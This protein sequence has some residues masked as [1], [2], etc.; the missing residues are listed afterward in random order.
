MD[1]VITFSFNFLYINEIIYLVGLIQTQN[2]APNHSTYLKWIFISACLTPLY[3]TMHILE[4]NILKYFPNIYVL[5][6]T[7]I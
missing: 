5:Y 7:V 1:W 2:Y 6:T 4:F 3:Y